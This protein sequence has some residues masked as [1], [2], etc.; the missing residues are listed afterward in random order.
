[1]VESSTINIS[2]GERVLKRT[3]DILAS[4]FGIIILSPLLLIIA[5]IIKIEDPDGPIIF[6]N[7]RV[8]IQGKEFFLYKFRYM[9]WRYCVKDAYGIDAN[10]D[11]GLQFEEELKKSSDTRK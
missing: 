4:F 7:R 5:I 9:Y 8:G 1:M 6:R 3:F 10:N 11:S 2:I